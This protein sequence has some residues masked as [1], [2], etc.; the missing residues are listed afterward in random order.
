MRS[1]YWIAL[2]LVATVTTGR[3]VHSA[4]GAEAQAIEASVPTH[5]VETG[6]HADSA[7]TSSWPGYRGQDRDGHSWAYPHILERLTPMWKQPIG[8]GRASFAVAG[9]RVHDRAA[10]S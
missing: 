10:P 5:T 6:P 3:V 8:G 2:P 9:G 1:I 4:A 7:P